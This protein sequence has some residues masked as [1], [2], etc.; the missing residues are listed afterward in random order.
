[1]RYAELTAP[2]KESGHLAGV[3]E[4]LDAALRR[5]ELAMQAFFRRCKGGDAPGFSR[6]ERV[7]ARRSRR[8]S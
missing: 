2:R 4:C 1:M 7:R 8:V 5:L 3:N 6:F